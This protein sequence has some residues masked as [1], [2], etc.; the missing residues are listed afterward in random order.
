MD[1]DEFQSY[2]DALIEEKLESD[3]NLLE[4]TERLWLQISEKR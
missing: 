3:H 4:E 2:V 1:D